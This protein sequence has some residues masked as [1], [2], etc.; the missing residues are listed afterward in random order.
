MT[1]VADPIMPLIDG[2]EKGLV[3]VSAGILRRLSALLQRRMRGSGA[4][5]GAALSVS[6]IIIVVRSCSKEAAPCFDT[7]GTLS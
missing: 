1:S 3:A 5:I 2:S 6:E 4:A 7:F